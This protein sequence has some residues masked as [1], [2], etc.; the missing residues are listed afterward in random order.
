MTTNNRN[1]FDHNGLAQDN[2][3]DCAQNIARYLGGG[4]TTDGVSG[5]TQNWASYLV[6]IGGGGDVA[7]LHIDPGNGNFQQFTLLN[8]LAD[9]DI[10]PA[11]AGTELTVQF[12][13]AS[14]G[15]Q[16]V[17]WPDAK[18]AAGT[19]PTTSTTAG[20]VDSVTYVYDGTNWQETA[21]SIANH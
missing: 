5:P 8:D 9:S 20:Y 17:S 16:T 4:G 19:A 1:I 18:Y 12:V 3:A 13:Q 11:Q 21:R 6:S 14:G 7:D 2:L 10:L 15:S